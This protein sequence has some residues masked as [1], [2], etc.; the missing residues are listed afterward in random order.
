[1]KIPFLG[2]LPVVG[3]AFRHEDKLRTKQNLMIF[4]TPTVIQDSDFQ[5]TKTEFL[6]APVPREFLDNDVKPGMGAPAKFSKDKPLL[7]Q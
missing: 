7:D 5:P 6:K 3:L 2:D 1:T 4:I